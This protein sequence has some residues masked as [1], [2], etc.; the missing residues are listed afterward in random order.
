MKQ[1]G[2]LHNVSAP[3]AADGED[4]E[5]VFQHHGL[6][7]KFYV[8]Q[9]FPPFGANS[10]GG[11]DIFFHPLLH[12]AVFSLKDGKICQKVVG[13]FRQTA[14]LKLQPAVKGIVGRD[15]EHQLIG[16]DNGVV[17]FRE[18]T[19]DVFLVGGDKAQVNSMFC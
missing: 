9:P 8:D 16:F 10:Q 2:D 12:H 19:S 6:E 17:C 3:D 1:K 4:G 7:H 13:L 18:N 15:H 14:I 11:K 5:T